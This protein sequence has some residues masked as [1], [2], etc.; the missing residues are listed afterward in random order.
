MKRN[1]IKKQ[2]ERP[3][4]VVIMLQHKVHVLEQSLPTDPNWPGGQPW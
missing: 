3:A 1:I 2:Y 4:I